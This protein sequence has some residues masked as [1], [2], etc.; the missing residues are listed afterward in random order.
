[1]SLCIPVAAGL[2]FSAGRAA[3]RHGSSAA[4]KPAQK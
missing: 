1:M 4:L 2:M 3:A